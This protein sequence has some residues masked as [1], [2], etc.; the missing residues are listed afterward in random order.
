MKNGYWIKEKSGSL[1]TYLKS[2]RAWC[3]T[4]MS[5]TRDDMCECDE[6]ALVEKRLHEMRKL[7]EEWRSYALKC[8]YHTEQGTWIPENAPMAQLDWEEGVTWRR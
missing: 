4:C 3:D 8:K 1:R 2:G 5:Y 6:A 7:K